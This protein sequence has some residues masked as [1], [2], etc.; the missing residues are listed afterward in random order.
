MVSSVSV[1]EWAQASACSGVPFVR[2]AQPH[3]QMLVSGE[4]A[5]SPAKK[6][7]T[8]TPR[9]DNHP[10]SAL[11]SGGDEEPTVPLLC[12]AC[13]VPG[14][15]TSSYRGCVV[16]DECGN[17]IRAYNRIAADVEALKDEERKLWHTDR[18][19]WRLKMLPFCKPASDRRFAIDSLKTNKHRRDEFE[20]NA[21]IEGTADLTLRQFSNALFVD[22]GAAGPVATAEFERRHALAPRQN[23]DKEDVVVYTYIVKRE[24]RTGTRT[25][26]LTDTVSAD[27][28]AAANRRG[29]VASPSCPSTLDH[30]S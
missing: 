22:E 13:L 12:E 7:K 5:A 6:R 30:G 24:K 11:D 16:H 8:T 14:A 2:R 18:P 25:S 10:D 26:T 28:V 23:A 19:Q 20:E 15:L 27:Q 29:L 17:G 3:H 21:N 4:A 1:G 9:K